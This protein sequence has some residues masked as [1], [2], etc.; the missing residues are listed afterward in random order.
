MR[1]AKSD[2]SFSQQISAV[3]GNWNS[4]TVVTPA[5]IVSLSWHTWIHYTTFHLILRFILI[6]ILSS[7]LRLGLKVAHSAISLLPSRKRTFVSYNKSQQAALLLNIILVKNSTCFGQTYCPSSR[8]LLLYSQQLL[9]FK[10]VTLS[11]C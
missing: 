4:M 11:V 5:I 6:L 2:I 8:V 10:Q 9:F 1:E 3:C 7:N